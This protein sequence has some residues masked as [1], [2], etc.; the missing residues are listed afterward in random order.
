MFEQGTLRKKRWAG[1][2]LLAGFIVLT[3][4]LLTVGTGVYFMAFRPPLLPEDLKFTGVA[5]SEVPAALLPWLRIVFRTWGGFVLGFGLCIL[6]SGV[7]VVAG[8]AVWS[9]AGMALGVLFA[10][11][12]FLAS[13]IQLNSNFLWFIAFLFFG[14]LATAA[15]IT[16]GRHQ[17][18]ERLGKDQAP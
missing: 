5:A 7:A 14:A 13:N 4:G 1:H 11:G 10:F 6:G 12:W 16:L 15:A 17:E 9:K 3:F 18:R 2:G 8:R